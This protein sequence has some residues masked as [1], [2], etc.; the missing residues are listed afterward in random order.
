MFTIVP[1]RPT[2]KRVEILVGAF[3]QTSRPRTLALLIEDLPPIVVDSWQLI[4]G[5]YS[6]P[7]YWWSRAIA[8]LDP[9]RSYS[10]RLVWGD[11]LLARARFETLPE[12]LPSGDSGTGSKRPFTLWLSSCFAARQAQPGLG[13]VIERVFSSPRL[14]P[15]LNCLVGDQVYL[16]ELSL[17]IYTALT[18]RRLRSRFNEQYAYTFTHPDFSRLLS[19]AGN[20]FLADD[21]ELWNN[22]PHAPFG[23]P[24][25]SARFWRRW[26][27]LAFFERCVPL[28]APL[29]VEFLTIGNDLSICVADLRVGRSANCVR[30]ADPNDLAQI[31]HWLT[32]LSCP[33]VLIT[34]QPVISQ[35]GTE[36]DRKLPDYRQYWSDLLPNLHDCKQDL[37]VLAGDVHH[38]LV[39]RTELDDAAEPRQLIQVIASPL[40]LVNP[41]AGSSP[42]PVL[43]YF[44]SKEA[45]GAARPIDYPLLVPT[46]QAGRHTTRSE[47]HSM[48][49]AFWRKDAESEK[50]EASRIGMRVR[51]WLTRAA[52]TEL[53]PSWETTLV[54]H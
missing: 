22:Y 4:D 23:L 17:L 12:R 37:V 16:D 28:Q 42:Q 35:R 27:E 8:G 6:Q 2:Q 21:H 33:G 40:A 30:F 51:T 19:A 25:R 50:P 18:T 1:R 53:A 29:P 41:V 15:H 34:Q 11:E 54:R 36:S 3:W 20:M 44:P 10:V 31:S 38:G 32:H 26:F 47:D 9:N 7:I 14:R 46:Y 13:D 43:H 5:G 48:T 45:N 24:L 52:T 49:I 39:A